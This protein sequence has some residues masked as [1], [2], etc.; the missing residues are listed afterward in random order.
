[1]THSF[2]VYGLHLLVCYE[3]AGENFIRYVVAV[4]SQLTR[5][6]GT[7]TFQQNPIEN[8]DTGFL[9]KVWFTHGFLSRDSNAETKEGHFGWPKIL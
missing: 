3:N 6:P 8:L 9:I 1:M 5:T 2:S 7:I 4:L